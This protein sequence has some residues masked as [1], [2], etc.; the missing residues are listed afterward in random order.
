MKK[1]S[2][3]ENWTC[4]GKPVPGV[5]VSDGTKVVLTGPDGRYSFAS[6]KASGLVFITVPAG[7][8]PTSTDGVRPDF[9]AHLSGEGDEV[10][11]FRLEKQDQSR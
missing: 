3:N 7:H 5:K 9:Y 4:G 8:V 10:H 11:D 2:F 1:L 6:D